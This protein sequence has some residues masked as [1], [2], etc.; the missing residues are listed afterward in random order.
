[1]RLGQ[2]LLVL[3]KKKACTARDRQNEDNSTFPLQQKFSLNWFDDNQPSGGEFVYST[4]GVKVRRKAWTF[5]L[6]TTE[7]RYFMLK[8]IKG[9]RTRLRVDGKWTTF[10]R[11]YKNREGSKYVEWE[12]EVPKDSVVLFDF[13]LTSSAKLHVTS[14]RELKGIYNDIDNNH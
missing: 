14:V 8:E 9:S 13:Q 4:A 11:E 5:V 7:R 3:I 2:N 6:G 1:M 12:Y 10:C